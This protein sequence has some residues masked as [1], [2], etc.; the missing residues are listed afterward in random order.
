MITKHGGSHDNEAQYIC[1]CGWS[2]NNPVAFNYHVAKCSGF[3]QWLTKF[4]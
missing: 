2:T 1:S 3:W 4:F